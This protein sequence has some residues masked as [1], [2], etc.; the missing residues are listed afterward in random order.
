KSWPPIILKSP[1]GVRCWSR[2]GKSEESEESGVRASLVISKTFCQFVHDSVAS[3]VGGLNAFDCHPRHHMTVG[4]CVFNPQRS[5]H[6]RMEH[7]RCHVLAPLMTN[8]ALTPSPPSVTPSGY[9]I[10]GES[11]VPSCCCFVR[12]THLHGFLI[13]PTK[14]SAIDSE[15]SSETDYRLTRGW[16]TSTYVYRSATTISAWNTSFTNTCVI[17]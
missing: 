7:L 8:E 1:R 13:P 12:W 2:V 6:N 17:Q 16:R 11:A 3:R 5:S 15:A 4:A 10:L 14:R 9:S